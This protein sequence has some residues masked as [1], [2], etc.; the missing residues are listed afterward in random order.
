MN[1]EELIL[2]GFPDLLREREEARQERLSQAE[3]E[4][5][6]VAIEEQNRIN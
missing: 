5:L 2:I 6:I 3:A 4:N 1:F